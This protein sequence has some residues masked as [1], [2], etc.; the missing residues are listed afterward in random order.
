M[1]V[2]DAEKEW[3]AA[4]SN[5]FLK[6]IDPN[7]DMTWKGRAPRAYRDVNYHLNRS[8]SFKK[9]IMLL[10]NITFLEAKCHSGHALSL[11]EDFSPPANLPQVQIREY[12]KFM[13]T[14]VVRDF[15]NFVSSNLHILSRTPSLLL[16]QAIN[17]PLPP[18]VQAG[19]EAMNK[20][21][22]DS[23]GQLALWE[24]KP[25]REVLEQITIG[26]QGHIAKC[27]SVSQV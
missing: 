26:Q 17:S 15:H 3:N 13:S 24:N 10:T 11:L 19:E 25:S 7:G 5:C 22:G 12:T 8:Y 27:L 1:K 6:V 20:L 2:T 16:Q 18:L 14:P 21:K 23:V 4:L 9:N